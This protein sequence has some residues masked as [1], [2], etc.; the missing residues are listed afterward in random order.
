MGVAGQV[1]HVAGRLLRSA[2]REVVGVE[3]EIE[4]GRHVGQA[5]VDVGGA[6]HGEPEPVA[7]AGLVDLRQHRLARLDGLRLEGPLVG[8]ALGDALR[9]RGRR[10][11]D[12]DG[13]GH[14]VELV[15]AGDPV[16]ALVEVEGMHLDVVD[17]GLREGHVEL[18]AGRVAIH[19]QQVLLVGAVEVD[20]GIDVLGEVAGLDAD[21]AGLGQLDLV[22]VAVARREE[23]GLAGLAELDGLGLLELVIGLAGRGG[24][25]LEA[26][27]EGVGL[28]GGGRGVV[29]AH[30][31]EVVARHE[32]PGEHE[33]LAAGALRL[34]K[35]ALR[36]VEDPDQGPH[37][38]GEAGHADAGHTPRLRRDGGLVEVAIAG[39]EDGCLDRLVDGD[40]LG[41]VVGVVGLVGV[42]SGREGGADGVGPTGVGVVVAVAVAVAAVIGV[43]EAE[44]VG[45]RGGEVASVVHLGAV[46][47][48]RLLHFLAVGA[49][50]GE[51]RR[52]GIGEAAHGHVEASAA[53]LRDGELVEVV[54]A[55]REEHGGLGLT[56]GEGLGRLGVVVGLEG[57]ARGDEVDGEDV[58]RRR[59]LAARVAVVA[60]PTLR[61]LGADEEGHF[62][63]GL[64]VMDEHCLAL[65]LPRP[66]HLR[67]LVLAIDDPDAGVQALRQL[68]QAD[69]EDAVAGL[70]DGDLVV[71]LVVAGEER[72]LDGLAE[73]HGGGLLQL[74]VRLEGLADGRVADGDLHGLGR[75]LVVELVLPAALAVAQR[76][77]V[78]PR[79]LEQRAV[80]QRV[81]DRP[82]RLADLLAVGAEDLD[83]GGD[84]GGHVAH[85]H[86]E[87]A[88][89]RR[90]HVDGEEIDI[91]DRMD[92]RLER[93]ARGDLRRLLEGVIRLLPVARQ[94]RRPEGEEQAEECED[95]SA[96]CV[97]AFAETER[98]GS[99]RGS[100]GSRGREERR[101]GEERLTQSRKDAK[102]RRRDAWQERSDAARRHATAW[103][104]A[105][106]MLSVSSLLCD[107]AALRAL[108]SSSPFFSATSAPSA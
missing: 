49:E 60:R 74:V 79:R 58:G 102:G 2:G 4:V 25:G 91:L 105:G 80:E 64:G 33:V 6:G 96:H 67:A 28:E 73:G 37:P 15:A 41:R 106:L 86:V 75:C 70:G 35:L 39:G 51:A 34:L 94:R 87:V 61:P 82:L 63:W 38:V 93:L 54:I 107:F 17:P 44:D 10:A 43:L 89:A 48:S 72:C 104:R 78:L 8:L 97:G 20:S 14:D 108:S 55:L 42:G 56:E 3:V 26:D 40:G 65:G 9:R 21:G 5:D 99:R 53:R 24:H 103:W 46:R 57:V 85:G 52:D 77:V 16:A 12:E 31:D 59:F 69:R 30:F 50:E 83:E 1:E 13:V 81:A 32:R 29:V 84:L 11:G 47:A 98:L 18:D 88:D 22:D 19:P 101:S 90:R 71:V 76:D 66:L 92:R 27:G 62:A 68:R 45:A 36:G 7:I 95:G 100:R 23:R